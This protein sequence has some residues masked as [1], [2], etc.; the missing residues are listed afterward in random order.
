MNKAIRL[1]GLMALWVTLAGAD[2]GCFVVDYQ[3]TCASLDETACLENQACQAVYGYP[4]EWLVDGLSPRCGEALRCLPPEEVF[5]ECLDASAD[6]CAGKSESECWRRP[7]CEAVYSYGGCDQEK[8]WDGVSYQGCRRRGPQ[9]QTDEDC[10]AVYGRPSPDCINSR[11]SCEDG[12]CVEH[13][14][15]K[16]CNYDA[17]CGEGRFCDP[18]PNVDCAPGQNCP[19]HCRQGVWMKFEPVLCPPAPWLADEEKNPDRYLGCYQYC[20]PACDCGPDP[21]GEEICRVRTFLLNQGILARDVRDVHVQD[22]VCVRCE[23]CPRG[24]AIYV[25]VSPDDQERMTELGFSLHGE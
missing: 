4:E 8:C 24:D 23:G 6:P 22:I 19:G 18:L 1:V 25:L 9:C 20:C 7:A 21:T 2:R 14:D 5:I 10:Y 3:G 12:V 17:D 13:C 15:E 11:L 16:D